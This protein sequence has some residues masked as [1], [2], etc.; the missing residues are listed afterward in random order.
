M[1]EEVKNKTHVIITYEMYKKIRKLFSRQFLKISLVSSTLWILLSLL[2]LIP[3]KTE[4]D[5]VTLSD[6]IITDI[7]MVLFIL[8]V[9][10]LIT[11]LTK[12]ITYKKF[13]KNNR[14]NIEYDIYFFEDYLKT[15]NEN[16]SKKVSYD[17][18]RKYKESDSILYLMIDKNNI[19]PI[20]ELDLDTNLINYVKYRIDNK[21]DFNITNIEVRNYITKSNKKRKGIEILLL[22]LFIFSF[23]TPW[24][25]LFG[26]VILTNYNKATDAEAFNYTYGSIIG[27]IIPLISFILGIKYSKEGIKCTK[28]IV[29]GIIMCSLI[30]MMCSM[31]LLN[32][33]L[34]FEKNYSEINVYKK[35]I[36]IKLPKEA[37][38]I[39]I[40]WDESYLKNHISSTAKF[41]N[42]RE[43]DDFYNSIKTN[44]NWILHDDI[45][46]NLNNFVPSSLICMSKKDKCYYSV[47]INELNSYN[48][49]P[50]ETGDYHIKA[51]M[52]DPDINT[53]KIEDFEY[54]YKK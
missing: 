47:Y 9:S 5:P 30:I 40:K 1:K 36:G 18:I 37:K 8:L 38:Y 16:I 31:S 4:T 54:N 22:L 12:K 23:F 2:T 25:G 35:I 27:I 52:Y 24:I 21:H 26:W 41:K 11:I 34:N 42:E 49:I 53:L 50:N 6:L 10:W 29:I 20:S 46:T 48:E 19:I 45:S 14:N 51:L 43:S 13:I 33:M 39:S 7:V 17:E 44:N 15:K 3:D 32:G 28:N